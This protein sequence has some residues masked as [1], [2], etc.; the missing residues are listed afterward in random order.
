M[1]DLTPEAREEFLERMRAKHGVD[2]V[3]NAGDILARG[4]KGKLPFVSPMM[5]WATTGGVP[6]GHI[7]R[8]YGHEHGGKSVTNWSLLYVAQNYTRI[9]SELYETDIHWLEQH[10]KALA[11]K[12]L[13]KQMDQLIARFPDDL[14]V[15]IYDTEGR[16]EAKFMEQIGLDCKQIDIVHD[17]VVEELCDS[18]ADAFRSGYHIVILDSA[19]NTQSMAEAESKPGDELVGSKAR[20]WTRWANQVRREMDPERSIWLVVDQLRTKIS[21]G[22][23]IMG[24]PVGPPDIKWFKHNASLSIYFEPGKKLYFDKNGVLTDDWEKAAPGFKALGTIDGKEIHGI[25]IKAKIEKNSTG[26]PFRNSRMRFQFPVWDRRTAELIQK[27]GWD[28][29]FELL[30][31]G[32]YFEI[33][34]KAGSRFYPLDEDFD[35]IPKGKKGEVSWHGE[36]QAKA[37]ILDDD[38]LRARI[39]HRATMDIQ[40]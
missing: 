23:G 10:N 33:I 16:A 28:E 15:V 37:G 24:N 5:T 25:E 32:L 26:R 22:S 20:A 4:P 17:N 18:M 8:S 11:G 31:M 29:S 9:I 34:D 21:L 27:V 39:L 7:V 14:K 12:K 6:W 36:G 3:L 1:N 13:A 35:R 40:Q 2:H 38:D 19:T 30:E